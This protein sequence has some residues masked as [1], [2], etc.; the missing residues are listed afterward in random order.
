MHQFRPRLIHS[1]TR[2]RVITS[3]WAH[4]SSTQQRPVFRIENY[5]RRVTRA[6]RSLDGCQ[7]L[8]TIRNLR[9]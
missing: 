7:H 6:S 3:P 1:G 9:D 4:A 5:R 2:W 8:A